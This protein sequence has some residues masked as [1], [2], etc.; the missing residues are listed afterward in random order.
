M[1]S[2]VDV[3]EMFGIFWVMEILSMLEEISPL[4]QEFL[5][6]VELQLGIQRNKSSLHCQLDLQME[7]F[8]QWYGGTETFW[9]EDPSLLH[10]LLTEQLLMLQEFTNGTVKNGLLLLEDAKSTAISENLHIH[11]SML[12][13]LLVVLVLSDLSVPLE[14]TFTSKEQF[15]PIHLQINTSFNMMD[16][17]SDN[18]DNLS[19]PDVLNKVVLHQ[20]NPTSLLLDLAETKELTTTTT[21]TNNTTLITKTGSIPSLDLIKLQSLLHLQ[22]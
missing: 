9:L 4:V 15:L 8:M 11:S 13:L 2:E 21:T 1:D 6:L 7:E 20:I 14:E 22:T 18:T 17:S 5:G 16:L 10:L 12:I 3:M 19:A